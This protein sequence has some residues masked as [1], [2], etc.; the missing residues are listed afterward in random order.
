MANTIK[1]DRNKMHELRMEGKTLQQI[2]GAMKCSLGTV[3]NAMRGI[4]GK[5][6]AAGRRPSFAHVGIIEAYKKNP[7]MAAIA[8]EFKCSYGTVRN[9]V[10]KAGLPI[11][12]R[13]R[14]PKVVE[15]TV[16]NVV[17]V[18]EPAQVVDAAAVTPA[19]EVTPAPVVEVT[20]AVQ[21]PTTETPTTPVQ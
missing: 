16:T 6:D 10:K 9:V 13:G 4:Y 3:A 20:P 7:N 14:K 8:A 21:V 1:F 11:G 5:R 17:P 2:A 15:P 18:T 12:P 19:V